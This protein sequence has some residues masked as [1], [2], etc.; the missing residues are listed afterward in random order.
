MKILDVASPILLVVPL[1]FL[2]FS[3]LIVFLEAAILKYVLKYETYKKALRDSFIVNL[4][5]TMVGLMLLEW[6]DDSILK[7][8][9]L[10]A[11][12]IVIEAGVMILIN[13]KQSKMDAFIG[14]VYMNIASYIVLFIFIFQYL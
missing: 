13:K 14:S 10:W 4:V 7:L 5:S 2:V 11:L 9:G 12:T 6:I 8:L 3:I 1:F